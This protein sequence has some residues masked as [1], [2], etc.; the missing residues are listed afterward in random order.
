MGQ[1]LEALATYVL[2]QWWLQGG[3][4]YGCDDEPIDDIQF[5]TQ[6]NCTSEA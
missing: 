6:L 4:P 5:G 1:L 3:L 2:H